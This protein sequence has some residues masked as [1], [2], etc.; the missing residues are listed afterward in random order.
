MRRAA[1]RVRCSEALGSVRVEVSDIDFMR[2]IV[3]PVRQYPA[4]PLKTD[5]SR[6]P[7]PIPASMTFVLSAHVKQ[8]L[9]EWLMTDELGHQM[10]RAAAAGIPRRPCGRG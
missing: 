5:C 6:A 2:G 10:G 7:V 8:F 9:S 3:N 1:G 4:G